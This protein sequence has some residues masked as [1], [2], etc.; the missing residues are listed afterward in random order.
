MTEAV[1]IIVHKPY[2]I[3]NLD[4]CRL[5]LVMNCTLQSLTIISMGPYMDNQT[6]LPSYSLTRI[7]SQSSSIALGSDL[8]PR[9]EQT[10]KATSSLCLPTNICCSQHFPQLLRPDSNTDTWVT[11]WNK[12]FPTYMCI[13]HCMKI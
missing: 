11:Y 12:L 9:F 13:L 5:S 2:F 6:R 1:N 10:L 8:I 4:V 3:L 7:R